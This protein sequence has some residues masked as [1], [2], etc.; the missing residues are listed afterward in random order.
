MRTIAVLLLLAT[1]VSAAEP[2]RIT[3]GP[4]LG[5]PGS[6]SIGVWART[7]R[8]GSFRVVY[9][10]YPA[11]L[12]LRSDRIA[13]RSDTD[14]TGWTLLRD[15]KPNT[16]YRYQVV[17][18]GAD[19]PTSPSGTFRTLPDAD[20]HRD[21]KHNPDGLFNVCFAS[22]SCANQGKHSIGPE[23]PAYRT[24]L[25]RERDRVQFAIMNGDF[26]YEEQRDFTPKQWLEQVGEKEEPR[27]LKLAPSLSGVW[28][29]YKLYLKR[30]EPLAAWHREV[31]SYFTFDDHEILN[32]VY[33]CGEVGLRNRRAVFRDIAL[34]GWYDYVGWSN[35]T[36]FTQDIHFGRAKLKS[37]SDVL[38]DTEADFTQVRLDQT[39][40][41]HVHWGT[42]DAGVDDAK[43]DVSGGD[44]NAGVYEI[45]EVL[46]KD[47]LRVRPAAK[48]DGEA[49]Y[50]I[51]RRSYYRWKVSNCE[52]FA[53]DTR[54]H[55]TLHDIRKPD[56][57][58]PTLLG[59][60]QKAWLLDG[61]KKSDADFLF[62]VSSVPFAIPHVGAGGMNVASED[63]DDAWT[64][65]LAERDE[66]V[67][68]WDALKKPVFVLTGDLHN[69][70]AVRV[71]DRV[72]EFCCGPHN[73]TNHPLSSEGGRPINGP[74][75]WHGRKCDIHWSTFTLDD[76]PLELRR[77]PVYC[78]VQVNNVRNVPKEPGKD[79]WVAYLRPQAVFQYHDGRTGELLY[80]EAIPANR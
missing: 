45:V 23:L 79:R 38:T 50:S 24:L 80:A 17:A 43:L 78:V 70:F 2:L 60:E 51:G 65:F 27:S 33:G 19:L 14:N 71:T 15:L 54:T 75:T 39:A 77:R 29:N 5:R 59:K 12:D 63:K 30:G 28:E 73:S 72:W 57:P 62:V 40:N 32:D 8:P 10:T 18:E 41:L 37:G 56:R 66:L 31:P 52:F 47:R 1:Q 34:R 53:V 6:H 68:T 36:T 64:A 9:G 42:P 21:P 44:P 67:K 55:R 13:T 58:G 22:G 46:S 49:A 48:H 61:M 7:N 26:I 76:V 11:R 74:F 69:S 35:P 3:H 25:N 16:L 20:S 4:V